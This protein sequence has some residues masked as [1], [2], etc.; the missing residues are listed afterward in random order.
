M[1][2]L[3]QG[4]SSPRLRSLRLYYAWEGVLDYLPAIYQEEG[5]F[6]DRFTRLLFAQYLDIEHN[7]ERASFSF[8][9]RV[10][11]P[12]H[13]RWLAMVVGTPHI[14]LWPVESLRELLIRRTYTRK[15]TAAG[16]IELLEI[17]VGVRPHLVERFKMRGADG[18]V[19]PLYADAAVHILFPPDSSRHLPPNE[20]IHLLV[21][22]FLP[23]QVSYRLHV[24]TE[25]ARVGDYSYLGVNTDLSERGSA[26]L[27]HNVKVGYS[28]VGD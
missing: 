20:A 2:L 26:V 23:E 16:L 8:D 19:D 5:S 14:E 9:P 28:E 10:A 6:L 25:G 22:S 7:I 12:E 17:F 1:E 27:G 4:T 21:R 11:S 13:I 15:G 3:C 18:R 24:L